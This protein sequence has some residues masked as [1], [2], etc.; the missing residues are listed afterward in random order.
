MERKSN[1]WGKELI[2][3]M[4][5]LMKFIVCK[6]EKKMRRKHKVVDSM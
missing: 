3:K 6:N 5:K 1:L 4:K 2:Q